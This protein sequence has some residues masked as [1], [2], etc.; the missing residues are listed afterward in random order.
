[1]GRRSSRRLLS[2]IPNQHNT[3]DQFARGLPP[4]QRHSFLLRVAARNLCL[5]GTPPA[6][7]SDKLASNAIENALAEVGAT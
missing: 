6:Y 5:G 2:L 4:D 1:M 3:I 7:V